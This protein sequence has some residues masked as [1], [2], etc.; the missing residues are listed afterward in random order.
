VVNIIEQVVNIIEQVV[1]IIEQVVNI[2]EQVVN[3]IEQ[4][5][6]II[7]TKK[8]Y[9]KEYSLPKMKK[10]SILVPTCRV[11]QVKIN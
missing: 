8:Q 7:H 9:L 4:V 5:V 6:N 1:N 11:S 3:I 2:I 10:M